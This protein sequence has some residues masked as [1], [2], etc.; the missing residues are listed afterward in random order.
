MTT[1]SIRNAALV[2]SA[3][4][5]LI[6]YLATLATDVGTIDS[7]EL[8]AV[9]ARLQVAHPTGYPLYTLLGR[10]TVI[11]ARGISVA[12]RLSLLS[13]VAASTSC[14]FVFLIFRAIALRTGRPAGAGIAAWIRDGALPLAGAWLWGI[15]PAL[16]EQAIQNEV[17]AVQ[18]ALV[19]AM[20]WAFTSVES[21]AGSRTTRLVLA[22]YLMG[23]AFANHM[24]A[25]Y[26]IPGIVAALLADRAGRSRLRA[27]PVLLACAAAAATPLLLYLVLPIRSAADPLLDWGDPTNL[28]RFF[29]HVGAA[30]YRVWLFSSEGSFGRNMAAFAREVARGA[31][32]AVLLLA[33]L[34]VS[35][36][37]RRSRADLLRF[38]VGLLVGT[39]WASGYDIHDL[40]PYYLTS[41]LCLA[42]LAVAGAVWLLALTQARWPRGASLIPTV[43]IVAAAILAVVRAPEISRRGDRFPR[44]YAQSLLDRL[45]SNAI[46][47]SRHWDIVVSPALYLQQIEGKRTDVTI[48][49]PELLR[50]T[51]YYPQLRRADPALLAPVEAEV[52]RFLRQLRLFEAGKPYDPREIEAAYRAVI[53]GIFRA[54]RATRPIYY[55][56]DVE[57]TFHQG[58]LGVPEALVVHV[59]ERPEAAPVVAPIDPAAWAAQARFVREPVRVNAWSFPINLAEARLRF[60]DDTGRREEMMRWRRALDGLRAIR[61]P[62]RRS[63]GGFDDPSQMD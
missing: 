27:R 23:L 6:A 63:G 61:L 52:E 5:P 34:G 29:R 21:A 12:A 58:W 41:R 47:F 37:V 48:V 22:F 32:V 57:P 9:C 39:A 31:G 20:L 13:A 54:H 59:L 51:W 45:E 28:E 55:T 15:H 1:R 8:A 44:L 49:D 33:L 14:A 24:T 43:A 10:V 26:W 53:A 19:S 25:V 42:A 17:H 60:L 11:L 7:G 36:F 62:E 50:R 46:L 16:W 4:G 3:A 38:G 30:Q 2:L 18:A 40:E 56:P 35:S